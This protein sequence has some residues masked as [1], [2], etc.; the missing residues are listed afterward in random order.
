MKEGNYRCSNSQEGYSPFSTWTRGLAWAMYGFTE[1]LVFIRTLDDNELVPAG[2][3][4][5]IE[6]FMNEV[7]FRYV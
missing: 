6:S 4:N 1:D 5:T 3:R 2:E 7:K